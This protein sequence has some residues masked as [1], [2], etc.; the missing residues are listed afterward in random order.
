M[1]FVSGT[2][3]RLHMS[4]RLHGFEKNKQKKIIKAVSRSRETNNQRH[5]GPHRDNKVQLKYLQRG[6]HSKIT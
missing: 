6:A 2:H 5:S 4:R 1:Q 3:L